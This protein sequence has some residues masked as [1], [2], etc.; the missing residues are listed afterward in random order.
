MDLFDQWLGWVKRTIKGETE[1][2]CV[3]VRKVRVSAKDLQ[4][5]AAK[6]YENMEVVHEQITKLNNEINALGEIETE[7]DQERYQ[8]LRA[9]LAD[10]N[11]IYSSFQAQLEKTLKDLEQ[12]R[13][14]GKHEIVLK[15]VVVVGGVMLSV[16]GLG[17]NHESPSILKIVDFILRRFGTPIKFG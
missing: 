12:L 4:K 6:I 14:S 17:L 8:K 9:E 16:I 7:E 10:K 3:R 1:E 13:K 11:E 5:N 2:N 15:Y